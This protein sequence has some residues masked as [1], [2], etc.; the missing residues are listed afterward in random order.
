[1]VVC[2]HRAM[3]LLL[4]FLVLSVLLPNVGYA[5]VGDFNTIG[6]PSLVL[7]PAYPSPGTEYSARIEDSRSAAQGAQVRWLYN[8]T[9]VAENTREVVLRAPAAGQTATIQAVVAFSGLS[10]T[11]EVTVSPRYLDLIIEP[12]TH[13]PEFYIG[14]ALPSVG[15]LVRVTGL[16]LNDDL[17]STEYIYFWRI[18]NTVYGGGPLRGQNSITFPMPQ[19]DEAIVSL[20]VSRLDN[21]ILAKR[22]L[23]VRSVSPELYWYEVNTL[24]GLTPRALTAFNMIGNSAIFRAEPY[25]LDSTVYNSPDV[26]EWTI[27]RNRVSSSNQNP[28]EITLE[29]TGDSNQAELGFKVRSLRQL[30]QG[31]DNNLQLNL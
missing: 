31:A 10:E 26:L 18:N 4:G 13:V 16:L 11:Y 5:Q 14:R 2:Y 22:T 8:G 23:S 3:R 19:G 21:T 28:Y 29:R 25:Y 30:L 24:Y 12:L 6:A 1:M 9:L 7:E 27:N 20:Q 15:S 17:D